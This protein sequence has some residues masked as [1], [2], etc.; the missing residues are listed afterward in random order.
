M[1]NYQ[2]QYMK[3]ESWLALSLSAYSWSG[4]TDGSDVGTLVGKTHP[5]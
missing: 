3:A 1:W 5:V 4:K 2:S